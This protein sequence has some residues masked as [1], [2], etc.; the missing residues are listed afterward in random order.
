M[1]CAGRGSGTDQYGNSQTS[2]YLDP[3]FYSSIVKVTPKT[4]RN[5][6]KYNG[7]YP[8]FTPILNSLS[9]TSSSAGGYSLVYVNGSNYLPNGTSFIKFG[10][11][12]NLDV[13][14]YSSFNLSFVVPQDASPGIYNVQV[15]NVYNGNF[16]PE[17]NQS[18]TGNLNYSESISY[19]II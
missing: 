17:V 18:Y 3:Q 8:S 13:V 19:T 9:T 6:R 1:S 12:G 2:S 14:Y 16:S 4:T 7:F 11:Y 15:V 5:C 10:N